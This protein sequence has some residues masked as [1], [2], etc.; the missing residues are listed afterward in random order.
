MKKLRG[1]TKNFR[2]G[3][4]L[5]QCGH[6]YEM[7]CA[8][9]LQSCEEEE[10]TGTTNLFVKAK[11]RPTMRTNPPFYKVF[12]CFAYDTTGGKGPTACALLGSLRVVFM[13]QHYY[14]PKPH[15]K[16]CHV[17]GPD[18]QH[19]VTVANNTAQFWLQLRNA[20]PMVVGQ[21]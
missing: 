3:V 21:I 13:W 16:V 19:V 9:V 14:P 5:C 4:R 2:T 11:C 15:A 20:N 17:H 6:V 1:Y 18:H 10:G 12:V 8:L 7:E